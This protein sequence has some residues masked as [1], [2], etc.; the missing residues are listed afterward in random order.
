MPRHGGVRGAIV[1]RVLPASEQGN[2]DD[3]PRSSRGAHRDGPAAVVTPGTAASTPARAAGTATRSRGA[4]R[5][6]A[7]S[8]AAKCWP[9]GKARRPLSSSVGAGAVGAGLPRPHAQLARSA[10]RHV[11][12]AAALDTLPGPV[13][14]LVL[15]MLT[16]RDAGALRGSSRALRARADDQVHDWAGVP[17]TLGQVVQLQRIGRDG[18]LHAA[19]VVHSLPWA[20]S[21]AGRTQAVLEQQELVDARAGKAHMSAADAGARADAAAGGGRDGDAAARSARLERWP[22]LTCSCHLHMT[23]EFNFVQ[24]CVGATVLALFL[25]LVVVALTSAGGGRGGAGAGAG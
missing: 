12:A 4:T 23:Y 1:V 9:L 2:L 5:A 11:R 24:A 21:G 13:W 7:D 18:S 25:T 16:L 15:P 8:Q 17:V 3:A 19:P 14:S 10:E 22:L 20:S 6:G